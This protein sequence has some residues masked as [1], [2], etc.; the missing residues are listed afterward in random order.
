MAERV[1][2]RTLLITKTNGEEIQVDIPATWKVTFGLLA[3]GKDANS[4]KVALRIYEKET[5]QRAIFVDVAAFRDMSIP[6]R[7]KRVNVQEKDGFV[8]CEGVR[9]RTTFQAK[10]SEWVNPDEETENKPKLLA[11][12]TDTEVFGEDN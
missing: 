5:M 10:T 9:K 12:P 6:M 4:G 7:V 11:M 3:P 1:E 2:I 8:E